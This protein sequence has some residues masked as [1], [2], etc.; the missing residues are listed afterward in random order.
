MAQMIWASILY[1]PLLLICRATVIRQSPSSATTEW[2]WEPRSNNI[3]HT[4]ALHSLAP[5]RA[6]AV[7]EK[8][9]WAGERRLT[10]VQHPSAK[11]FGHWSAFWS[12]PA[13]S[14][15]SFLS[16]LLSHWN[17]PSLAHS[18]ALVSERAPWSSQW[19]SSPGFSFFPLLPSHYSL[20]FTQWVIA[21]FRICCLLC[22]CRL[23]VL[24]LLR[25]FER[26]NYGAILQFSICPSCVYWGGHFNQSVLLQSV[27]LQT[28]SAYALLQ[29]Q[30]H[31][32]FFFCT[33]N[34]IQLPCQWRL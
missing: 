22:F 27:H 5:K 26:L 11:T 20:L 28:Q 4:Q 3:C 6:V 32:L 29:S 24:P 8:K 14:F 30:T 23:P 15:L 1:G 18:I 16:P 7:F 19:V 21:I 33:K 17:I 10:S 2:H 31:A 12:L 13:S 25:N 9:M 34:R